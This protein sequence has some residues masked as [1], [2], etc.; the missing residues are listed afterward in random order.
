MSEKELSYHSGRK[1]R[2]TTTSLR[3][4]LKPSLPNPR[5]SY[6]NG[7][8]ELLVALQRSGD[9]VMTPRQV[10]RRMQRKE[11]VEEAVWGDNPVS[12]LLWIVILAGLLSALFGLL[13]LF[14]INP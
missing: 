11:L 13:S 9:D 10:E 5:L 2:S 6:R 4:L 1:R 12:M 14:G 8:Q 3:M 7:R